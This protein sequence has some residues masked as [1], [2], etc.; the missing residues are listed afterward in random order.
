MQDD[1]EEIQVDEAEVPAKPEIDC[2]TPR[3]N[4]F[5]GNDDSSESKPIQE[6]TSQLTSDTPKP[7]Q[8]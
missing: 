8:T 7:V 1:V 2:P 4:T 3:V 6:S 5:F